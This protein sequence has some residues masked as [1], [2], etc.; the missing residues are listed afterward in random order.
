MDQIELL[1]AIFPNFDIEIIKSTLNDCNNNVERSLDKLSTL[2]EKNSFIKNLSLHLKESDIKED[3]LAEKTTVWLNVFPQLLYEEIHNTITNCNNIED[4]DEILQELNFYVFSKKTKEAELNNQE[5]KTTQKLSDS[6]AKEFIVFEY[7]LKTILSENLLLDDKFTSVKK[8]D[9]I[10][11]K[12]DQFF[13]ICEVSL[14]LIKFALEMNEFHVGNAITNCIL[15]YHMYLRDSKDSFSPANL[16][17]PFKSGKIVQRNRNTHRNYIKPPMVGSSYVLG[18]NKTKNDL[19]KTISS[20]H[21]LPFTVTPSP[22]Q[23]NFVI[24][25]LENCKAAP[26]EVTF[27]EDVLA[28]FNGEEEKALNLFKFFHKMNFLEEANNLFVVNSY[29]DIKE[30][31]HLEG[32]THKG[33][34]KTL[35]KR[36]TVKNYTV[37]KKVSANHDSSGRHP[38]NQFADPG[39]HVDFLDSKRLDLHGVK[40]DT[41]MS[42]ISAAL[43]KWWNEELFQREGNAT[44]AVHVQSFKAQFV[45]P[46]EI[47]TGK[48]LH[49][50]SGKSVIK[51]RCK[52]YLQNNNYTFIENSGSFFVT[53]LKKKS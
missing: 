36:Y 32:F 22:A 30:T 48:G 14:E 50:E 10:K 25:E 46:L 41:A 29:Q 16:D 7:D 47:I 11:E 2:E 53:G 43:N 28:F 45:S 35:T 51:Q 39:T 18:D 3:V 13:S 33:K 27:I 8:E 24:K 21:T 44:K 1:T 6:A 4:D 17:N 20:G 49:S 52:A 40:S 34:P 15:N 31:S 9:I 26:I 37:V 38:G 23:N 5:Q 42:L 19:L 12:V